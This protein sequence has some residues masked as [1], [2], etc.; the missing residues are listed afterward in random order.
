MSIRTDTFHG[1]L[2]LLTTQIGN[3][4]RT[5]GEVFLPYLTD[6]LGTVSDAVE[7]FQD[8]NEEM[9]GLPGALGLAATAI[10]GIGVALASFAGGPI[11]IAIGA[12]AALAAAFA[13]DFA[14]IRTVTMEV[15][16]FLADRTRRT[17]ERVRDLWD[18]WGPRLV[19]AAE[20]LWDLVTDTV[21]TAVEE[22]QD[23]V[24]VLLGHWE[25]IWDEHGDRII[26]TAKRIWGLIQDVVDAAVEFYQTQIEDSIETVQ[27]LWAI[28]GDEL[29]A[30]VGETWTHI[31]SVITDYW[32]WVRPYV[33]TAIDTLLTTI[34]TGLDAIQTFWDAW[35]DEIMFIVDFVTS[36][37]KGYFE[38]GLDALLTIIKIGLNLIQGDW[39]EAWDE[40]VGFAER[41]LDGLVT[42]AEEWGPRLVDFVVGAL[43]DIVD[44]V[45]EWA[46]PDEVKSVLDDVIGWFEWLYNQLI[47]GSLIPDLLS[48]IKSAVTNWDIAG[49]FGAAFGA[50]KGAINSALD[51]APD[52]SQITGAI[53]DIVSAADDALDELERLT[54]FDIDIDWPEPPDRVQDWM[55]GN[56]DIDW[57]SMPDDSGDDDDDDDD[58]E[59][60]F[61]SGPG[62][63]P[64]DGSQGSNPTGGVD[65]GETDTSTVPTGGTDTDDSGS[66][67]S[68][69]GGFGLGGDPFTTGFASGGLTQGAGMAMLHPNEAVMGVEAGAAALVDEMRRQGGGPTQVD[70]TVEEVHA[71]DGADFGR[72]L[73]REL[74]SRGWTE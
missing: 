55:D 11:T 15:L 68:G 23:L 46:L 41:T 61:D 54:G 63:V 7:G 51:F 49:A 74:Q 2:Q 25:T 67:S 48:D 8:F 57:P 70:V 3:V 13:T 71:E 37:V 72:R 43:Q 73:E 59:D 53:G 62:S 1:Q 32:E 27:H 35:G 58:D 56:F 34:N 45:L 65:V 14:G 36:T 29:V 28:H 19:S 10:G 60:P 16:D 4:A 52:V 31:R 38:T 39:E 40:I 30:E 9:D 24:D 42:F 12:V 26:S 21:D 18:E 17:L 22:L 69:G 6:L 33:S 5:T 66:G 47:G 64:A 20:S 44:A 50:V